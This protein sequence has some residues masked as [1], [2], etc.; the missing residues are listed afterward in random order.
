MK[1]N[2]DVIVIG[3]GNGGLA[4][5]LTILNKGKSCLVLEKHNIPGGFATSFVR[6]RFEFEASLHEFNGI[7]TKEQ[8]GSCGVLLNNLGVADKIEWVPLHEAYRL[9]SLEEKIDVTVPIGVDKVIKL[10]D[11][12]CPNGGKYVKEFLDLANSIS[13]AMTYLGACHGKP[14]PEIM[15]T[16][17]IN[18]MTTCSYSFKEVMDKLNYPTI[19]RKV[20]TGY[21][22][23]IGAKDDDMSFVHLANM[24]NSYFR[25]GA[26]VPTLRSHGLSLA[27]EARIHELGGDIYFNSQVEKILTDETGHVSGVK[28]TNGKE[29]Y[30]RHVIANCSPHNVYSTML[31]KKAIPEKALKLANFQK[32]S[33]RGFTIFL[34]LNKSP[35]ELGIKQHSYFVYSSSD[36]LK[37]YKQMS[38]LPHIAG[39]ATVCLNNALKDC[40]PKGTTILY[41]TTLFTDD[42]WA[43]VSEKEYAKMKNKMAQG[44]IKQFEDALHIN[45]HD[46]IEELAIASPITYARY[47]L[48]PQGVIYG[49]YSQ[50]YDG[51]MS[52]IQMANENAFVP[53]LRIGGGFG[54]R[55]DGFPS[56]YKSGA[57]EANRTL[58]D[59]LK[60]GK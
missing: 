15:K 56:S 60:E 26:C 10:G 5:A 20:L 36:N 47:C 43:K 18:Y 27:F 41:I 59:M 55:L 57:N 1:K 16:K 17:Y 19:I 24:I 3:A 45:I 50:Y 21:W 53:G 34:G 54:E 37:V 12:L 25:K 32:F 11:Q 39:Q 2:Y 23:Y 33:G 22:S 51:L 52:R 7:G 48:H 44:L 13:E 38:K 14:D 31:D 46:H 29:Y 28:L 30:A 35:E 9:I 49:Y 8:P 40:S 4:A 6:G 42:C 58:A